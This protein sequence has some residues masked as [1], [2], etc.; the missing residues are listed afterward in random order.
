MWG[1]G[2]GWQEAEF[3]QTLGVWRWTSERSTLRIIGA[4]DGVRITMKLESPLR[5]FDEPPL[6]HVFAGD[7]EISAAT[8]SSDRD[9][10][11]E[12]PKDALA[13]SSGAVTIETDKTFVPAGRGSA[14][15]Q[16]HL[17]LRV[18][19]IS[20]ANSLTSTEKPR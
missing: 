15:D 19:E 12:V 4:P 1:Y 5:Y 20:V 3:N 9:W 16:R 18:F 14:S 11:F 2:E 10:T 6:V 13:A 17:G 8:I 7:R